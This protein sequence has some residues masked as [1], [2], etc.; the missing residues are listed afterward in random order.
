MWIRLRGAG[1]LGIKAAVAE[2]LRTEAVPDL[3]IAR[4]RITREWRS[5]FPLACP[6][7]GPRGTHVVPDASM[8]EGKPD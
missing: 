4:N 6:E 5:L 7:T 1:Q 8:S 3:L 2:V